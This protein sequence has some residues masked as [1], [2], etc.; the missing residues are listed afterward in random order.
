MAVA[1]SVIF[2][3]DTFKGTINLRLKDSC[4]ANKVTPFPIEVGSTVQVRF[5]GTSA[6]VVL[7]TAVPGEVTILDADL[8]TI[9]YEG[10]PTKSAL[11]KKGVDLAITVVVTQGVSGEVFTF[12]NLKTLDVK[13]RA[14]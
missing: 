11:L 3:G 12:E 6:P 14:N 8:S 13:S 9:T 7:S 2:Q 1:K 10:S 4:D 5:A